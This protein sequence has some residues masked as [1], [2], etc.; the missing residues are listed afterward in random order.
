MNNVTKPNLITK[1][2]FYFLHIKIISFLNV[3]KNDVILDFGCGLGS[4]KKLIKKK[5]EYANV[6]NFD[7]LGNLSEIEDWKQIGFNKIVFCQV[8][9]LL[10]EQEITDILKFIKSKNENAKIFCCFSCQGFLNK[11]FAYLLGHKNAHKDTLTTPD[12]E[13]KLLLNFCKIEKNFN[14]LNIFKIFVLKF[15]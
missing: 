4:L 9:Y 12:Q 3:N 10:S 13:E 1:V 15:I 5:F 6:I 11:L 2:Y 7:V 14:F 8:L